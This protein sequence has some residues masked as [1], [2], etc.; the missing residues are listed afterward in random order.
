VPRSGPIRFWST[1]NACAIWEESPDVNLR[2]RLP[3]LRRKVALP[4]LYKVAERIVLVDGR[5]MLQVWVVGSTVD[6][7]HYPVA[8]W[9]HVDG[10]DF[11]G[12]AVL[13]TRICLQH[14]LDDLV[15]LVRYL[16]QKQDVVF[17]AEFFLP[18]LRLPDISFASSAVL[19]RSLRRPA[20]VAGVVTLRLAIFFWLE[21][22]M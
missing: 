17:D 15:L 13:I 20:P 12:V 1:A 18:F 4:P 19:A 14:L 11:D 7:S 5:A 21:Y 8:A 3:V 6:W 10:S 16:H 22:G 2:H 9:E